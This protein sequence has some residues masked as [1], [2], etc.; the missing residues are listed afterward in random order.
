MSGRGHRR[1]RLCSRKNY[2]RKKYKSRSCND[3]ND[4]STV[5]I[6]EPPTSMVLSNTVSSTVDLR[7]ELQQLESLNGTLLAILVLDCNPGFL[8]NTH[9][10]RL[11][12]FIQ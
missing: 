1:L 3:D 10:C 5:Q 6:G 4:T 11:D 8:L 7:T 9:F 2:E 12:Y